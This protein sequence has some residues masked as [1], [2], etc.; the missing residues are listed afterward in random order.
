[1]TAEEL[2][3]TPASGLVRRLRLSKPLAR[4]LALGVPLAAMTSVLAGSGHDSTWVVP[5]SVNAGDR[6]WMNQLVGPAPGASPGTAPAPDVPVLP[7]DGN[8]QVLVLPA[9]G[10]TSGDYA[11]GGRG[12]SAPGGGPDTGGLTSN[13]IPRR[14]L[15]AYVA[16]AKLAAGLD[17]GCHVDWSL[18]AGIGRV[19]TDH[20]RFGGSH[21]TADGLITPPIYGPRLNGTNGMPFIH[22]TDRG[23]LDADPTS[24][25]AVGP[26]QFIPGTWAGFGTD[27]DKDGVANP[28]DVDDAALSAARYLCAGGGDLSTQ[29][30][31]VQAVY[32]YNHSASYVRLVL[33]LADS[34]ASGRPVPV[35]QE[36]SGPAPASSGPSVTGGSPPAVNPSP[37]PSG[38][39]TPGRSPSPSPTGS[40]PSPTSSTPSPTSSTPSPTS[41]TPSPT[42]S[43]PSPTSSTPSPT[44]STPSPTSSTP[45]PTSTSPSPTDTPTPKDTPTPTPSDTPTPT[46]SDTPT[47]KDTP[48]PTAS[49]TPAA[50]DTPAASPSASSSAS[51]TGS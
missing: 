37:P 35:S 19:E 33:A 38:S 21:V 23:R 25:R 4:V 20:G 2:E 40:T 16:A 32:R 30:G 51:P 10:T 43:T 17:P 44:S 11:G 41:S 1:M 34:Y 28:Q 39:G 15:Q 27:A 13:G 22:D 5:S 42:S 6:A 8:P 12:A 9:P 7:K 26:M 50:A 14:V 29:Q 24:D 49:D 48:T 47:P 18:L 3:S 46:P 31:R 45:S 36:P